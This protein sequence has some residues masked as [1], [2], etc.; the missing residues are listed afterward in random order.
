MTVLMLGQHLELG[1]YRAE[2]LRM[3]GFKVIFP[4]NKNDAIA[5]IKAAEF[6]AVIVSYTLPKD[7]AVEMVNLVKSVSPDCPLVAITQDPWEVGR[8]PRDET[9]LDKDPPRALIDALVRIAKR[10]EG[11]ANS[12]IRRIK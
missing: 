2:F 11:R 9:I 7:V 5:A 1:H 10:N 4:E 12:G 8:Y 6:D 3:H